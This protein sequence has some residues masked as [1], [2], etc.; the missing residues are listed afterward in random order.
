MSGLVSTRLERW[1]IARALLAAACRRRRSPG[2]APGRPKL[3]QRSAPGPGRAPS[4]GTGR[5]R[6]RCGSLASTCSAGRLKQSDLPL[7]VAGRDDRVP[8]AHDAL[9]GVGLV[10]V[11]RSMPTRAEG[12]ARRRGAAR[13]GSAPWTAAPRRLGGCAPPAARPRRRA[14]LERRRPAARLARLGS[15]FPRWP[16]R[17]PSIRPADGRQRLVRAPHLRHDQF[18]DLAAARRAQARAGCRA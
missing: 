7:A 3:G 9:P 16:W 5:A 18:A 13:P 11:E 12:R 10:R 4:S 8:A 1:R 14:A 17:S 6:A 2:A 15:A